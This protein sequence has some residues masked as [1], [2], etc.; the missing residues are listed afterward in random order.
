MQ[1]LRGDMLEKFLQGEHVMRHLKGHWNATWS[2]MLIETTYIRHGKGILRQG[3][4]I[5]KTVNPEQVKKIFTTFHSFMETRNNLNK[6]LEIDGASSK[7]H[8]EEQKHRLLLDKSDREALMTSL[9][10]C[11]RPLQPELHAEKL[12]I[13]NIFSG[14]IANDKVNIHA[15]VEI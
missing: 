6:I 4:L 7:K 15:S 14:K 13:V 9:K 10:N 2:D 1:R 8:R 5:G 12:K 3:G 11:L